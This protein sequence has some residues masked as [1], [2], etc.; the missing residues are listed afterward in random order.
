MGVGVKDARGNSPARCR[1]NNKINRE[2]FINYCIIVLPLLLF[3]TCKVG[4]SVNDLFAII[5]VWI[6][7][8]FTAT[9]AAQ[10]HG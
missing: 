6:R 8:W 9:R 3:T 2:S 5:V 4:F 1:E 7:E 10:T